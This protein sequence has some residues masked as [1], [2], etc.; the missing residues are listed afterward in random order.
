M[1]AVSATQ[2]SWLNRMKHLFMAIL[3]GGISATL[4]VF[5]LSHAETALIFV[6]YLVFI[7][8]YMAALGTGALGGLIASLAGMGS[9]LVSQP[10][11][12]SF[13]YAF[14]YAVPAAIIGAVAILQ[15]P[16]QDGAEPKRLSEGG[17]LTV[18]TVYP[19]LVFLAITA[20][21]TTHPGGLLALTQDA[22][23][24]V[25]DQLGDHF[26]A[27]QIAM[28]KEMLDRLAQLAPTF[29]SYAWIFVNILAIGLAQYAL[30]TYGWNKRNA[31]DMQSLQV[32][33]P[34]IYAV[35]ITGMIGSFA[36][37]P[38]NY[39]DLNLALILGLPFLFVGLAI[40]HAWA[41]STGRPR[42]ILITFYLLIS[43]FVGLAL[44]VALLGVID[45]WAHFRQR[46]TPNQNTTPT[47]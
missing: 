10:L 32:P 11:N 37:A 7:P 15:R 6:A 12:I 27:Q 25:T 26:D 39:I 44:L 30:K 33:V 45:Q 9:L 3:A 4:L 29:A 8:L 20:L 31:F 38:F 36:P 47:L 16:S 1:N 34:L 46:F 43:L 40:I 35:A 13:V 41:A 17:L 21:T 5:A 18:I 42:L 24:A 19:C 22:F 2:N 23:H 28:L 14:L